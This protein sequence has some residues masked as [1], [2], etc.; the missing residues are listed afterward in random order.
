MIISCHGPADL[1][2]KNPAA[3][4]SYGEYKMEDDGVPS[5]DESIS[6]EADATK[7]LDGWKAKNHNHIRVHLQHL[8]SELTT[9]LHSLRPR[10]EQS[11]S[12]EVFDLT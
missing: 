2:G 1:F 7:I 6:K 3:E 4:I 12:K 9:A 10:V 11:N 5:K 8:E